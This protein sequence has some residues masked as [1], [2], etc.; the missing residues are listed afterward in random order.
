MPYTPS[1][2]GPP[3]GKDFFGCGRQHTQEGA[4]EPLGKSI[5]LGVVGGRSRLL[6]PQNVADLKY[7][8]GLELPTLVR[9]YLFRWGEPA[10]KK[11]LQA[12]SPPW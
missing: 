9:V 7:Q 4:V 6:D 2:G 11:G 10:T 12:S 5:A 3:T 8:G 1:G